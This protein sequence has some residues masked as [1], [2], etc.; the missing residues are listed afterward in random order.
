LEEMP[1]IKKRTPVIAET[2]KNNT[3]KTTNP[4]WLEEVVE[5]SM[6]DDHAHNRILTS[7][8]HDDPSAP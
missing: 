3:A 5:A 4:A 1:D 7:I 8:L 2:L 6:N